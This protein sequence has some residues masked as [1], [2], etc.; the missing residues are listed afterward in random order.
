MK[1][2]YPTQSKRSQSDCRMGRK[3]QLIRVIQSGTSGDCQG[4]NE[5]NA[6]HWYSTPS[7]YELVRRKLHFL[8]ESLSLIVNSGGQIFQSFRFFFNAQTCV[9]LFI[10]RWKLFVVRTNLEGGR[11][12]VEQPIDGCWTNLPIEGGHAASRTAW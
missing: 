11:P 4:R 12:S 7:T 5:P 6:Y 9:D 10:T 8:F 3:L 2:N 1:E